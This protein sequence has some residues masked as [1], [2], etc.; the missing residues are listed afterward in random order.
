MISFSISFFKDFSPSS[1]LL[2]VVCRRVAE[3]EAAL[4]L[5]MKFQLLLG[6]LVGLAS[7]YGLHYPAISHTDQQ[8][9]S[10][11]PR[12]LY[13][14]ANS[15]IPVVNATTLAVG[16]FYF[17]S[18][19]L[20]VLSVLNDAANAVA[21]HRAS[22]KAKKVK[23]VSQ[24]RYQDADA[25]VSEELDEIDEEFERYEKE[26]REYKES[27]A[28]YLKNYAEWAEKYGQD[29]HPPPDHFRRRRKRRLD[30]SK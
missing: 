13:T 12:Y 17:G 1:F 29:P 26:L 6:A 23:K 4:R 3:A 9:E 11:Q 30:M 2:F 28:E 16:A 21:K 10:S 15:S 19:A 22:K 5:S 25:E 24:V 14:N 27:Y 20:G 18:I 7:S 8:A